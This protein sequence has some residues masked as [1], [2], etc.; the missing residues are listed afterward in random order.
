MKKTIMLFI[1]ALFNPNNNLLTSTNS[2]LSEDYNT[3]YLLEYQIYKKYNKIIEIASNVFDLDKS[4]IQYMPIGLP[5]KQEDIKEISSYFGERRRHPIL[6]RPTSHN[7]IDLAADKYTKVYATASGIVKK[8]SYE[9]LGFGK[10]IEIDHTNSIST[11][12]AHLSGINVSV[13]DTVAIGT[14]IGTVGSTGLSTG[15]HLHYE[16]RKGLQSLNPL[17]VYYN[18]GI[19]DKNIFNHAKITKLF[20][21]NSTNFVKRLSL[22]EL[23]DLKDEYVRKINVKEYNLKNTKVKKEAT[24]NS[25]I[26]KIEIEQTNLIRIKEMLAKANSLEFQDGDTVTSNNNNIFKLA[27]LRDT[28]NTLTIAKKETPS[29]KEVITPKLEQIEIEIQE[30]INRISEFNKNTIVEINLINY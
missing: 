14:F 9:F 24:L 27:L 6:L 17:I 21:M 10:Y 13:G 12:Y 11:I 16:I 26:Y 22:E 15:N 3:R 5:I 4:K 28:K 30:C 1:L 2:N 8:V 29:F 19:S 20:Q 7:G 23:K 25:S 18:L